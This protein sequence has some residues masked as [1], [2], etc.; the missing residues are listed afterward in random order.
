MLQAINC[1]A[2]HGGVVDLH[3]NHL[4]ADDVGLDMRAIPRTR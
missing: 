3:N 1:V 4:A 2:N